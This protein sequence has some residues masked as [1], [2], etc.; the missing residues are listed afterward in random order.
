MD[1]RWA[2]QFMFFPISNLGYDIKQ[3][4]VGQNMMFSQQ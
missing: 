3:C 4:D 2:W 1:S